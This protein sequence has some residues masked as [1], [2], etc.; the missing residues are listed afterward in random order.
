[1][2]SYD[3]SLSYTA[4]NG[5]TINNVEFKISKPP[6]TEYTLQNGASTTCNEKS[7][8]PGQWQIKATATLSSD[9]IIY[10][11][12]VYV[13]VQYPNATTI[14]TNTTVK[15]KMATLW[16]Q[17]KN[18]ASASGRREQGLW[19]FVNTA[20][21]TYECGSTIT[22]NNVSGC[23]GTNSSISAGTIGSSG[24]SI[25]NSP[26]TGGK[27]AVAFFHTHTPLTYCPAN[28]VRGVGPSPADISWSSSNDIPGIVYDYTGSYISNDEFT[29][30]GILG[31]HYINDAAQIYTV[32]PNKRSTPN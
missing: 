12:T 23:A 29:G 27:Y 26:I 20:T 3:L 11:N 2:D 6:G 7:K 1:M 16:A 24:E 10:S 22:G 9:I 18:G 14:R 31:C 5:G 30:T 17:T 25:S 15:S 4:V 32:D 19:I 21:M 8:K 13:T 28:T